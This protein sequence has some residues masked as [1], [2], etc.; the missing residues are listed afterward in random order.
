MAVTKRLNF[1]EKTIEALPLP[2]KGVQDL[3]Y[4]EGQPG[5]CLL[6]SYGGSKTYFSYLKF[7]GRPQKTK[8]GR[9][10]EMK[11]MEARIKAR[12]LRALADKGTNPG[13]E[14]REMLDDITLKKFYETVYVPNYSLSHKKP[15]SQ[16][17][18]KSLFMCNLT[19]LHNRKMLS[20][21]HAELDVLHNKIRIDVSEY[22][23]NRAIA[24]LKNMYNKALDWGLP[25][26][27][28]NP[29]HGIKMFEEKSRERFLEPDEIQRFFIALEEEPNEMFKNYIKLSL[30]IGQ[31]RSNM[32]SLRWSNINLELGYAFFPDTKNGSHRIPLVEQAKEIL[33]NMPRS[34]NSD[35]VFPS[36]TSK[37]GHIEDFHRPW[38][39]LLK[40]AGIEDFRIHD[41]RRTFGS[42]QAMMGAGEFVLGKALGDKTLAAVRVYARMNLDPARN[43]M[44]NAINLLLGF[45]EP[46]DIKKVN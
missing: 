43:S 10:G 36:D 9:A 34:P 28:G 1:T 3:Y 27:Y 26:D 32:L 12:E 15:K 22:T 30:F 4:D 19:P 37:S 33:K 5:L 11:L 18:D 45:A 16:A 8:I 31:R 7:Q 35:F 2:A 44:Q 13:K 46:S 23:A 17:K 24:L 6:V 29:A 41:I 38:Y 42:Y 21:T 39:A 20:I 25:K 40:R 14:R